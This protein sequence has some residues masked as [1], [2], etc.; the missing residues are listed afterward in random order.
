MLRKDSCPACVVGARTG[1]AQARTHAER[2]TGATHGV[3]YLQ[4]AVLAVDGDTAVG[5]TCPRAVSTGRTAP[6]AQRGAHRREPNST[7]MVRSWMGVNRRS[8]NC[9]NRHD[10]PTPARGGSVSHTQAQTDAQ[11]A[12]LRRACVANAYEL[13]EVVIGGHDLQKRSRDGR[14]S[15]RR[16]HVSRFGARRVRS[17]E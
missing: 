11:A 14:L 10:L 16:V 7:P 13:H 8:V 1:P 3:P 2:A 4:F 15:R 5:S 17:D 9:S 12:S 6:A